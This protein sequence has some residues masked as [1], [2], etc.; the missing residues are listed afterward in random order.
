MTIDAFGKELKQ[1]T[2]ILQWLA[3]RLGGVEQ[4]N[5][6]LPDNMRLP[7]NS[8]EDLHLLEQLVECADTRSKV[9]RLVTAFTEFDR[10]SGRLYHSG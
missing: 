7:V 1:Q 9:V 8:L 6:E 2:S 10:F 5:N 3:G 4:V